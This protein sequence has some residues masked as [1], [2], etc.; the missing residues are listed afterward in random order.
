MKIP[1]SIRKEAKKIVSRSRK[2]IEEKGLKVKPHSIKGA[3]SLVKWN[4][5]QSKSNQYV[6]EQMN[7]AKKVKS[8]AK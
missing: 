6:N 4:K 2:G 8:K 1:K 5:E 7:K 3:S